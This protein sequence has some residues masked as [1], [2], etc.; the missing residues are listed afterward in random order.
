R[1]QRQR[2]LVMSGGYGGM[3]G[4]YAQRL[5]R[6]HDLARDRLLA[7][8]ARFFVRELQREQGRV[9]LVHVKAPDVAVTERTQH[10]HAADAEDHFL[11]KTVTRIAAVEVVGQTTI[12]GGVLRQVRVEEQD[13]DDVSG[14][15][16]HVVAPRAQLHVATLDRDGHARLEAHEPLGHRPVDW[17]FGLIAGWIEPLPEV[18]FAVHQRY[19]HQWHAHIGRRA[20]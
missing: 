9:A 8:L 17:L 4:E 15:A 13:R 10:A 20:N 6:L 1:H 16:T 18:A 14:N 12:L 11:T 3:R 7:A 19:S 2:E 5:D